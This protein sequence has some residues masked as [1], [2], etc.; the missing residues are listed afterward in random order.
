MT[1]LWVKLKMLFLPSDFAT[2]TFDSTHHH[3]ANEISALPAHERVLFSTPDTSKTLGRFMD[4]SL[5]T[6][7]QAESDIS[8]HSQSLWHL[9]VSIDTPEANT[10]SIYRSVSGIYTGP[11]ATKMTAS[12][13]ARDTDSQCLKG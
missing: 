9:H 12:S 8:L 10:M 2:P 4:I 3:S 5:V 11:I 7:V 6:P 13:C 1:Q